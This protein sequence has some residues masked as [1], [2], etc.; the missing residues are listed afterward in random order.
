MN[1][2]TLETF[3]SSDTDWEM[4]QYRVLGG[5]KEYS[6]DFNKKK[7]YPSLAHLIELSNHLEEILKQQKNI[8]QSFPKEIKNFDV[9]NKMVLF[10]SL[11]KLSPDLEFLFQ[12]IKWAIPLINQEIEEGIVLYE[13]VEK[14]INIEQVGILPIYKDE[15]YFMVKDNVAEVLQV[16]K[17]ECSLFTSGTEKF[18]ALK[19]ELIKSINESVI[20]SP[21]ELIKYT[22]IKENKDLPNPATFICDTDLDFPFIETI[23]PIAKRKLISQ[24]TS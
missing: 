6:N 17:Y 21:P 3:F 16:H 20:E 15:G 18:R 23:F 22:L 2:L 14:N 8:N 5:I 24:I 4:N 13:F 1:A 11:E 9:K 12:L 7:L 19:T 10:E